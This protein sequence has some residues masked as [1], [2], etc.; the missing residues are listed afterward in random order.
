MIKLAAQQLPVSDYRLKFE[1]LAL[2]AK[3]MVDMDKVK[4][5]A[6]G[7]PDSILERPPNC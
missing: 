1:I 5:F 6:R 2:K 7:L 3:N 4:N